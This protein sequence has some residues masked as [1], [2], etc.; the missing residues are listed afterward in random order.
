M[1]YSWP[2]P[3][4]LNLR[5]REGELLKRFQRSDPEFQGI[6]LDLVK[7][8]LERKKDSM[9]S[10]TGEQLLSFQ[11]QARAYKELAGLLRNPQAE[12]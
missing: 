7:D 3:A 10:A 11:G 5:A 12:G 1:D 6:V 8:L 2:P 4:T 9:I